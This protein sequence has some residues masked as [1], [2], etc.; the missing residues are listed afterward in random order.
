MHQKGSKI[1]NKE[2]YD[3]FL[4]TDIQSADTGQFDFWN[5]KISLDNE[6]IISFGFV[7]NEY[8]HFFQE[9][10][11][12]DYLKKAEQSL[13]KALEITASNKSVYYR[14]LAR[15]Y[16]SQHRFQDALETANE[17]RKLNK[18]IAHAHRLLFDVHM[19]L[20]NYEISGKYVDSLQNRSDFG[21]LVRL[22][23]WNAHKGN[24]QG[25][26][27]AMEM[28]LKKA[29]ESQNDILIIWSNTNLAEYYGRSGRISESYA[30]YLKTLELDPKNAHAKK[31][32][33]WIVF[34]HE[35]NPKE[36]L[37]ILDSVTKRNN[38]PDY[39]LLKA[40][41]AEYLKDD[42]QYVLNLD[43]YYQEIMNPD[44]GDIYNAYN[45][46]LYAEQIGQF[47]KAIALAEKEVLNRPT[48]RSYG[49][50]AYSYL[51]KGEKEKAL[52]IVKNH[53]EGKTSEPMIV[54]HMAE[55]YKAIG[56][57]QEVY[58]LKSGLL[59]AT[60]EMGPAYAIRIANL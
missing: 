42:F 38:T 26:V 45:V 43:A 15:N 12:I 20:G 13:L 24:L 21:Y 6:E 57:L 17:A 19:E 47:D 1:T 11:T 10:R 28:A 27:R 14:A 55:I 18:D 16:L 32:I 9:A 41:I 33:A 58:N 40:Q 25:G 51:R 48:P 50:L 36:A 53:L 31:G 35:K 49:L 7:A 54:Y 4:V 3:E 30:C 46:M 39:Y 56:D 23:K 5:S 60:Y 37:R 2:D 59:N 52:E 8:D 29:D 34:S 22:A 44:Y